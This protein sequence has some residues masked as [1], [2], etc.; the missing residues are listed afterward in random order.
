MSSF[1]LETERPVDLERFRRWLSREMQLNGANIYRMKGFLNFKGYDERV[2]V[3]GVHMLVDNTS[4]GSWG[5]RPRRT[6]LVF[7]G[8][9]LDRG[10]MMLG[11]ENCLC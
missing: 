2:V 7:I 11:F 8:K 6:Q 1:C 3:Q 5:S 10:Q 4:L 9:N